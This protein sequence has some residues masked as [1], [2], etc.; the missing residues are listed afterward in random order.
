MVK[1]LRVTGFGKPVASTMPPTPDG[2]ELIAALILS[3]TEVPGIR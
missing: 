1:A 2:S 3:V